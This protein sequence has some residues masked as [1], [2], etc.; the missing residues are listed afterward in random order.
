MILVSDGTTDL[1]RQMAQTFQGP[2]IRFFHFDDHQGKIACLNF[3]IT[4][5]RGEIVV[6]SDVDAILDT[7]AVKTLC[8]HFLDPAVGGVCGRRKLARNR[9]KLGSGQ[10]KF[11]RWD[12][13]I[14]QLEMANNLSVTSHDGKLYAIQKKLYTRIPRGVTDDAFLSLSVVRQGHRFVFDPEA[15]AVIP[16]PSYD[17]RHE[18]MR[19]KRIV[20]ASLNG[21]WIHRALFDVKKCKLFAAGLFINKVV[22]RALPVFLILMLLSSFFLSA[23]PLMA[24]LFWCQAAGYLFF[25]SFPL[26]LVRLPDRPAWL[27]FIKKTGSTGYFF[28]VG[29]AGTLL[30]II[31]FL[32]GEKISKWDPIKK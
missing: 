24:V 32:S 6:F 31:S 15:V 1:S 5:C 21:L 30:G 28:C 20:S 14:K 16:V 17:A 26:G 9:S 13:M 27:R 4:Q 22:R 25:L 8:R 10:R 3:G 12:T 7:N 2:R 18:L 23:W 19:R 29:M 11:V